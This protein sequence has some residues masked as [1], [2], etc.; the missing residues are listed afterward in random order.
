MV[1]SMGGKDIQTIFGLTSIQF[2]QAGKSVF[3]ILVF[4]TFSPEISASRP[5]F[6]F[7]AKLLRGVKLTVITEPSVRSQ[8]TD[9][10]RVLLLMN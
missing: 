3:P 8:N 9:M 1:E 4:N 5:K 6:I 7:G 2:L 10:S